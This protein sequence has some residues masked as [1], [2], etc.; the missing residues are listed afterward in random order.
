MKSDDPLVAR[1][2]RFSQFPNAGFTMLPILKAG[3]T[4]PASY[5]GQLIMPALLVVGNDPELRS[6]LSGFLE[7]SNREVLY[8][9]D[10]RDG[11]RLARKARP[12]LTIVNVEQVELEGLEAFVMLL[13]GEHRLL[14]HAR[15][16][17]VPPFIPVHGEGS[18]FVLTDKLIRVTKEL[19]ES[20]RPVRQGPR[21]EGRNGARTPT[22]EAQAVGPYLAGD[23]SPG[24][25]PQVPES[26]L[27]RGGSPIEIS[28]AG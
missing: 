12:D 2:T 27:D 26:V 22:E 7:P 23:T 5:K 4:K 17:S 25:G 28:A 9:E 3:P 13:A 6:A 14:F 21:Y 1:I 16:A 24:E 11:F 20:L 18:A 19:T 10:I 8:A 15:E